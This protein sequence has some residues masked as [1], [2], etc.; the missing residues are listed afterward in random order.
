[1]GVRLTRLAA[2]RSLSASVRGMS[3]R[4]TDAPCQDYSLVEHLSS[5]EGEPILVLVAA[6]GAGSAAQAAMGARLACSSFV[7]GVLSYIQAGGTL[8]ALTR[9]GAEAWI[10]HIASRLSAYAYA[11]ELELRD[12]ASTLLAAVVGTSGVAYLQIGDGAIVVGQNGGGYR[13]IFWPQSGEYAN[14]TY[15]VTDNSPIDH[16]DFELSFDLPDEIALLTDGLQMLALTYATKGAH[17]PFFRPLFARL[18]DEPEH[19]IGDLR[20]A[21][22]AW[23]DSPKINAR[24]DD[25][26]TLVLIARPKNS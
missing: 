8:A 4:A 26:K 18:R 6:D 10:A 7:E 19:Q 20:D 14:T 15:F 12:L 22:M 16:L 1:M 25:D 13:P 17:A 24:T 11:E 23:L 3:H 2:W 21:L 5:A 9:E